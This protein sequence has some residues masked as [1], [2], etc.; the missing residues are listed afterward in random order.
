VARKK[1]DSE[2]EEPINQEDPVPTDDAGDADEGVKE[3]GQVKETLKI[4]AIDDDEP[5]SP[6][7]MEGSN[8]PE[9]PPPPPPAPPPQPLSP[10][11]ER[12]WAMLA[13]LSVLANLV[14]GF[15]GPLI[16]LIIYLVFKDRSRYVAYQSIQA[17]VF[18]MVWWV[19]AGILVGIAWTVSGLLAAI[20]IGCCLMPFALILTFIPL[21]AL[22][23]GVIGAIE[24]S[25][26]KDFKYWLIGDWTRGT[27]KVD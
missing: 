12:T 22:V 3:S 21:A 25:Q 5:M 13:H 20:L 2:S 10:S 27:L 15:L 1:T 16:A 8:P 11:D 19:G 7:P 6:S 9:A 14:T 23:Y 26:G 4:D 24:T 18:Q 17:F